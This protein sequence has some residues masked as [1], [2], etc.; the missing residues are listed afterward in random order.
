[1]ND[2]LNIVLFDD[3]RV[4]RFF[5]LTLTR[6]M[7]ELRVGILSVKEKW[8]KALRV[9]PSD[10]SSYSLPHLNAIFLQPKEGGV[11]EQYLYIN[12]AYF[13]SQALV[14]EIL[15]LQSKE[16]LV[17]TQ[18]Q[19]IALLSDA[20][21]QDIRTKAPI[22]QNTRKSSLDLHKQQLQH[23]WDIF[24][25]NDHQI[26]ADIVWLNLSK[27]TTISSTNQVIGDALYVEDGASVE[28]AMLN[29]S[30]GPIYIGKNSNIM[31]GAM[32]RGPVAI[33]EG[34]VVKM[35]TKIYGATTIGPYS[36]VGGELN[37]SVITGYSNKGHDGF[38]GNSV[39]G[40]WCNLG[41][42]TNTSNLKNNY[43]EVNIW[44]YNTASFQNS[45][46]QFVGLVMGDHSKSAINT[47]FN[48]GTVVGTFCTLF[49][50]DFPEKFVPD[51]SWGFLKNWQEHTFEKAIQTARLVMQRRNIEL[52][53]QHI[54]LYQA[55]LDLTK[56]HRKG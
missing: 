16:V 7:A 4:R 28:C 51:F 39:I 15:T 18:G 32:I 50:S 9:Q 3:Q 38:L 26:R 40:E 52:T 12:S 42:D 17:D 44:S 53:D 47:M 6:P 48:T 2:M 11:T 27:N 22:A 56:E 24:E 54:K 5:P 8:S 45:Q 43:S 31:E 14:E 20:P 35:G 21:V 10:I 41:A 55:V 46:R 13:P 37:N 36:K 33:C 34:G 19:Q 23:I 29:T 49:G 30:T 25:L 1:M